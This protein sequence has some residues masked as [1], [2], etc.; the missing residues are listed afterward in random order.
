MDSNLVSIQMFHNSKPWK[1]WSIVGWSKRSP[2][3]RLPPLSPPLGWRWFWKIVGCSNLIDIQLVHI[4][5]VDVDI[6]GKIDAI[7]K[8]GKYE[9]YITLYQKDCGIIGTSPPIFTIGGM[10]VCTIYINGV[11]QVVGVCSTHVL[12]ITDG[13]CSM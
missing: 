6:V 12:Y 1:Y 8:I 2:P 5:I 9:G 11:N 3:L 4:S 13:L 10:N 7:I